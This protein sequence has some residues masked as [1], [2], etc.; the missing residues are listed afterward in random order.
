MHQKKTVKEILKKQRQSCEIMIFENMDFSVFPQF[1]VSIVRYSFN[2]LSV[3][4][5]NKKLFKQ[6]HLND[7]SD[8]KYLINNRSMN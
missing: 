7:S 5:H 1:N 8:H 4:G 3:S 6:I 2:P